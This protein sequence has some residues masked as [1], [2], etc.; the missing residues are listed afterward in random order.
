VWVFIGCLGFICITR[1]MWV[2]IQVR[3]YDMKLEE[4]ERI[5]GRVFRSAGPPTELLP[6]V[7]QWPENRWVAPRLEHATQVWLTDGGITDGGL[8]LV[9]TMSDVL[10]VNL[11]HT[12][13]SGN[14][15][16]LNAMPKL[17][18]LQLDNTQI[19]DAE[20]RTLSGHPG[21]QML[22]L[23][24]TK[25]TDQSLPQLTGLSLRL[26]ALNDT[27][28]TDAGLAQLPALTA[29][30]EVRLDG[31]RIT[32]AGLVHLQK[33]LLLTAI[34]LDRT[35]ISDAGAVHLAEM[36]RL[37]RI[38]L[39]DTKVTV[40]GLMLF[41]GGIRPPELKIRSTQVPEHELLDLKRA[42]PGLRTV[43]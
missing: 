33:M 4:I 1:G 3:R 19:T 40:A 7:S 8:K 43:D 23:R 24:N 9:S 5:G 36:P 31:T 38:S 32:D 28:I 27:Q 12:E 21:L 17:L 6:V 25:I 39:V 26:L 42:L 13:I 34:S 10:G 30:W 18:W 29:L 16:H 41:S 35:D 20:L 14:L 37:D 15:F 2:M 11:S 22:S